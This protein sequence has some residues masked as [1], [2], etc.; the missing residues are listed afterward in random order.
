VSGTNAVVEV[1]IGI[2]NVYGHQFVQNEEVRNTDRGQQAVY[3]L[4][5]TNL[6]VGGLCGSVYLGD[7]HIGLVADTTDGYKIID[8]TGKIESVRINRTTGKLFINWKE[9]I[10]AGESRVI[11]SYEYGTKG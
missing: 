5:Q 2:D 6:V 3:P 4:S 9:P 7:Q 1:D 10:K 8:P 11:V